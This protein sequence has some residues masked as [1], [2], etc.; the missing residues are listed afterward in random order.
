MNEIPGNLFYDQ[1]IRLL[2]LVRGSW[3]FRWHALA[4]AWGVALAGWG[5]VYMLP[6]QFTATAKVFVDTDSVLPRLLDQLTVRT[7]VIPKVNMM[8]E[9][10][11]SRPQLA[12]V[13]RN[14]D[15]YLRADTPEEMEALLD[16]LKLK[17][18]IDGRG[19]DNLYTIS[20]A[21][22]DPQMAFRLVDSLLNSFV[23]DTLGLN[24]TDSSKAQDFLEHEI[25]DVEARLTAA[26]DRRAEFRKA[27]VG[28]L[29]GER[30]D[31][32]ARL[33]NAISDLDR[34]QGELRVAEQLRQTLDSQLAGEEPQYG[35]MSPGGTFRT[36]SEQDELG[37]R[38]DR[39]RTE[40]D[41][42][43][44]RYTEK[45][46]DVIQLRE[47]IAVL[48]ARRIRRRSEGPVLIEQQPLELNPVY[49]AMQIAYNDA[50]IKVKTLEAQVREQRR[51]V[52]NLRQMVDTIP[53]VEAQ[54][55]RLNRDYDVMKTQY[56]ALLSRLESARLTEN[57]EQNRNDL[58]FQI[59][60]PPAIPIQPSS[61]N[62]M[63]FLAIVLV[64][65]I[66]GG[67]VLA[68]FLHQINPVFSSKEA[69]REV[70]GYPVLGALTLNRSA[71][72]RSRQRVQ[73]TFFG[74]AASL[75]LLAFVAVEFWRESAARTLQALLGGDVA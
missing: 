26:E 60:E 12:K 44:L 31:Y 53:E 1:F 56:E 27:N 51:E 22:Y 13:A 67:A 30:G 50:E 66:G 62:R 45:H 57:A 52:N 33:E 15:L 61:P 70:L 11:L 71:S 39:H 19:R 37:V 25:A 20:Y 29:P 43:L 10:L 36:N 47:T 42:L 40:L 65:A 49:Q 59:I 24:K 9:A 74:L 34:L 68:L 2:A 17:I 38:I 35:I 69:L 3:R 46:P 58:K 73:A 72:E 75:L 32:Y 23:E 7:N 16:M 55:T 6:D 63:I 28:M 5:F 21:D 64:M 18:R 14:T 4:A 8:A 48:E 54:L 41:A